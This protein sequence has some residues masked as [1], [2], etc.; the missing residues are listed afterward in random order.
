LT[1]KRNEPTAAEVLASLVAGSGQYMQATVSVQ[2]S[3]RFPIGLFTQIENL[4]KMGG[5]PVSLIINQ[6]IE[7]GLEAVKENLPP[8]TVAKMT[9][10]TQKQLDRPMVSD[11]VEIKRDRHATKPKRTRAK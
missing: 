5:V 8:E 4:A 10:I 2:R 11:R 7:S 9:L 6:L 1:T 3:H